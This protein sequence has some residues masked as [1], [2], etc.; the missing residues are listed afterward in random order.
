MSDTP[1]VKIPDMYTPCWAD[2]HYSAYLADQLT[3]S[4]IT[5][6]QLSDVSP[7]RQLHASVNKDRLCI[8]CMIVHASIYEMVALRMLCDYLNV[9]V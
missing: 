7:W 1:H 6:L 4:N 8:S 5:G 2:Y 9:L 3:C